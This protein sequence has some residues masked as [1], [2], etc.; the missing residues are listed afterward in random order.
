MLMMRPLPLA[1]HVRDDGACHPDQP[2]E[3][4]L[5]DRPRLVEGALFRAGGGDTEA[6]I[7]DEEVDA[8]LQ[9]DQLLDGSL[10]RG[11]ARDVEGQHLER[12]LTHLGSSPAG[13]VDPVTSRREPLRGHLA[14]S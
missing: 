12:P 8:S 3:V 13:A 4:R 2:E 9:T 6:R 14:D 10:H 11:V 1:P 5:E 7:V